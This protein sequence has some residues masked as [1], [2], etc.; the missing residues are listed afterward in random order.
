MENSVKCRRLR[1]QT[2]YEKRVKTAW[3]LYAAC[4]ISFSAESEIR[5]SESK[6][7]G[8][9][10]GIRTKTSECSP[11]PFKNT[12]YVRRALCVHRGR[13]AHCY[14]PNDFRSV[15]LRVVTARVY[16]V[17]SGVCLQNTI[18]TFDFYTRP[19][20]T[21]IIAIVQISSSFAKHQWF[22]DDEKNKIESQYSWPTHV[23]W[24]YL[25]TSPGFRLLI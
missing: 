6:R 24:Q 8:I 3:N 14:S 23:N 10:S 5:I 18:I 9:L 1:T 20:Y 4:D 13:T 21:N 19:S 17:D 16:R 22:Q 12:L 2:E 7:V 25:P 15:C 11:D